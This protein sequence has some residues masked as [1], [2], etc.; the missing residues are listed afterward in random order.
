MAVEY[1]LKT[2]YGLTEKLAKERLDLEGYNE[3][4]SAKRQSLLT[5][6][7]NVLREPIL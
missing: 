1:N 7:L 4:P 2:F 3:L 5:I 6:A